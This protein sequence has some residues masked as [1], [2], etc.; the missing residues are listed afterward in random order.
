VHLITSPVSQMQTS[1]WAGVFAVKPIKGG[2][3]IGKY[4]GELLKGDEADQRAR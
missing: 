1:C 4:A 3:F 2:T